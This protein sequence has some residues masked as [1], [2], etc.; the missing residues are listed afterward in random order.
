MKISILLTV[1]VFIFCLGAQAGPAKFIRKRYCGA[2][3]LNILDKYC[4][5]SEKCLIPSEE[6]LHDI[7]AKGVTME[8]LT[9]YCCD[10]S[11]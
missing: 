3:M 10:E 1:L 7:C 11:Q 5:P 4:D 6:D 8:Q 9:S 2:K